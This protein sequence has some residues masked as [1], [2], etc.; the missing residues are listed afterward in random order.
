MLVEPE[1]ITNMPTPTTAMSYLCCHGG[2]ANAFTYI[3]NFWDATEDVLVGFYADEQ[4]A[5]V[6]ITDQRDF[7]W[8]LEVPAFFATYVNERRPWALQRVRR[9]L[10]A[11]W[12]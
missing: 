7:P 6:E 12:N 11:D 5:I 10:R 9:V 3:P 1:V 2:G 4:S 8:A